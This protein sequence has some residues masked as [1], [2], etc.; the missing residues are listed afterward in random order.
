MPM[1]DAKPRDLLGEQ[2]AAAP[3]SMSMSMITFPAGSTPRAAKTDVKYC[4]R[5][6]FMKVRRVCSG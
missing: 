3:M 4:I 6:G 1:T 5:A 2:P